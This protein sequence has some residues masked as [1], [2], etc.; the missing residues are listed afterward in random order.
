MSYVRNKEGLHQS[1]TTVSEARFDWSEKWKGTK[2]SLL[3]KTKW[4]E[5]WAVN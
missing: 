5:K 2:G 3:T 1:K 4:G